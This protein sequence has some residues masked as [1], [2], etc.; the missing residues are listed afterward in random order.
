MINAEILFLGFRADKNAGKNEN[1]A[2]YL[3]KGDAFM[4]EKSQEKSDDR[5]QIEVYTGDG[6]IDFFQT[7]I[8]KHDCQ[9]SGHNDQIE[10]T[11]DCSRTRH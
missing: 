9:P 11:E 3:E 6:G 8:P 4:G 5:H 10:K 2:G 1:T 7:K